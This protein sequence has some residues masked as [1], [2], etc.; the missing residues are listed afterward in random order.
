MNAGGQPTA[1]RSSRQACM[2]N[3]RCR[4]MS[5]GVATSDMVPARRAAAASIEAV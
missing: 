4:E 2:M 5:L 1:P 3:C